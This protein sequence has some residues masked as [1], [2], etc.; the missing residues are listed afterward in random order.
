MPVPEVPNGKEDALRNLVFIMNRPAARFQPQNADDVFAFLHPIPL[1]RRGS[2]A[3]ETNTLESSSSLAWL[4]THTPV[5][6]NQNRA[7]PGAVSLH[8]TR[9]ESAIPEHQNA[10]HAASQSFQGISNE[11][12]CN[13]QCLVLVPSTLNIVAH[14]SDAQTFRTKTLH[15]NLIPPNCYIAKGV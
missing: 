2:I 9:D 10:P 5:Q 3:S 11:L 14:Y 4:D 8:M 15:D 1:N 12:P 13:E 7:P 6:F